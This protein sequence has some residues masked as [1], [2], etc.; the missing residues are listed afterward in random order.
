MKK[1]YQ[2]PTIKVVMIETVQMIAQSAQMYGKNATTSAM[3]RRES[4]FFDDDEE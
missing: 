1:T 4:S 2:N 3:G